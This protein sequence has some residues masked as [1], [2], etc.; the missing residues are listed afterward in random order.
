[1]SQCVHALEVPL[2]GKCSPEIKRECDLEKT[3]FRRLSLCIRKLKDA[4]K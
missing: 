1:M 2:R 3:Y 4:L